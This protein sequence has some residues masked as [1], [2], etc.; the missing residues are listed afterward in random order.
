[1]TSTIKA[2]EGGGW[3]AS[4]VTQTPMGEMADTTILE[5]DSLVVR[6]R[7]I[8][9]GPVT[10]TVNFTDSKA[11]GSMSANGQD[12]P[13]SADTG[14]P[15]FGDGAG[16]IQAIANL[17]LADGYTTVIRSFDATKQQSKLVQ[18]KV[19]GTESVTVPAGT[20]DAFKVEMTP[21]DGSPDRS[22][23]WVDKAAHK[24]VKVVASL[25]QMNG[26]VMTI[27]LLP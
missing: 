21:T 19:A 8:Q 13:I 15:V 16:G 6:K 11:T 1:M 26:A 23:L 9:Q 10:I 20:F 2:D 5:K 7:T 22:T 14:G 18:L 24:P 12:H 25:P 4:D 27:E 3:A 17:P